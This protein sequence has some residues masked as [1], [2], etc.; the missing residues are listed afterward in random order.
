MVMASWGDGL[1]PGFTMALPTVSEKN[2]AT[3]YESPHL[4]DVGMMGLIQSIDGQQLWCAFFRRCNIGDFML[5]H[6]DR[7]VKKK[8]GFSAGFLENN[9]KELCM[10]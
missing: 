9:P 1:W 6:Y 7:L 4:N 2:R 3:Q 8:H 5:N 10:A